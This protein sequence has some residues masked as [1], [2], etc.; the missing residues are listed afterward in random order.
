M[1]G[2][3][4]L[5]RNRKRDLRQFIARFCPKLDKTRVKFF[6]HSLWGILCS[7]S[8]TVSKWPRF[9]KDGC[10][11]P[12]Y[13]QKRLLNQFKSNDWNHQ[14]VHKDYLQQCARSIQTDTTLIIDLSDLP[15]PRARKLP[16]V[17][18]VRD[19]SDEGRLHYGYWCI[20]IY[21]YWGKR[22]IT[23]LLLDPFSIDA[24]DV[25]SENARIL[26]AVDQV[27]AATAGRGV[28]VMD[29]AADRRRLLLPFLDDQR[30]FVIRLTG[31]RTL[32]LP[33]GSLLPTHILADQLLCAAND[34]KRAW[35]KVYLPERPNC[36]LHL[37]C[38]TLPGSERP[39]ILLTSLTVLD[40]TSAKNVLTYY[41]RRWRCEEAA[42]FLK[43]DLGIEHFALRLYDSFAPLFFLATLAMSFLTW[44]ALN[45]PTLSQSLCAASP[46]KHQIKFPY[47]RLLDWLQNQ[48]HHSP[49]E[50]K[51]P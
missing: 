38:K 18:L 40:L 30:Q 20:E 31:K 15:R 22:R 51:P 11:C 44:L 34:H 21:A 47:Y 19:G 46:G 8:L 28:L 9:I 10:K 43:S 32:L 29:R 42:R 6:R 33:N 3:D 12:F 45:F 36:P 39:L 4:A 7:G 27:M 37:V 26:V 50:A 13:T 41:R 14:R 24:P 2:K 35:C 25:Y 49:L 17:K 48:F 1:L 23:P 5:C 16:Y